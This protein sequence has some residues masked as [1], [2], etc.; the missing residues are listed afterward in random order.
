MARLKK[1]R[2]AWASIQQI[3]PDRWRIRYW[4]DGEDGYKRRSCTVRGTRLDAEKRRAELMLEHGEDAPC[5]T[6]ADAWERWALPE[7]ERRVES[8]DLASRTLRQYRSTWGK[9]VEP[10]WGRVQCDSV[11]PLEVQQWIDGLSR[12]VAVMATSVLSRVLDYAVRYEVAQRNPMR[13]RYIMPSKQTVRKRDDGIWTLAELLSLSEDLR[14]AWFEPAFLLAAFG[15]LRVGESLGVMASDVEL[16]KVEGV[17]V[18][19]VSVERQ[20]TNAGKLSDRLKTQQ[21]RRTAVLVGPPA[22]RLSELSELPDGWF[23]SHDGMGGFQPQARLNS[24]WSGAHPFCNLRNSWE[25]WCRW[26]LRVPTWA[27]ETAMGHKLPGVTGEHYDRPVPDMLAE[28][29]AEAYRE[30]P[31]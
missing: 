31:F 28:L 26:T 12:N 4:A 5:P 2:S 29:L 20:V 27:I 13:E 6:V 14:G 8:G 10:R 23:L 30:R 7:M 22:L 19:L 3:D 24:S 9:H 1:R 17:T 21:S 16:R 25:T 11:R 15:G 18:A